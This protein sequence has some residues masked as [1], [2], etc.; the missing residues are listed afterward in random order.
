[1]NLFVH[2]KLWKYLDNCN[3]LDKIYY[4]EQKNNVISFIFHLFCASQIKKLYYIF[5]ENIFFLQK[6]RIVIF[7]LEKS[8]QF[9]LL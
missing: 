4:I 5:Y 2:I 3:I 8:L 6:E 9:N 1:M 7:F